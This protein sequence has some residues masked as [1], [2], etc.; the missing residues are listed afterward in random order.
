MADALDLAISGVNTPRT[1]FAPL[2]QI[3]DS[4]WSGLKQG[5]EQEKQ[6]A[7]K[8]I[9]PDDPDYYKKIT[10]TLFKYGDVPGAVPVAGLDIQDKSLAQVKRSNDLIQYGPQ[11]APQ[12]QQQAPNGGLPASPQQQLPAPPQNPAVSRPQ[13]DQA[14]NTVRTIFMAANRSGDPDDPIIENLA[15]RA[16]AHPD[17]PLPPQVA[18]RLAQVMSARAA[19]TPEQSAM[20][21]QQAGAGPQGAPQAPAP[22]QSQPQMAPQGTPVNPGAPQGAPQLGAVTDPSL[23][24]LVPAWALKAGMS[25]GDFQRFLR[26]QVAAMPKNPA[27]ASFVESMT[28]QADEIGTA[29]QKASEPTQ[30]QKLIQSNRQTINGVPETDSQTRSR[31]A[32]EIKIS[33]AVGTEQGK[34]IGDTIA[35]GRPAQS[36]IRSLQ[37]MR[38]ALDKGEGNFTTGPLADIVLKSKQ[39]IASAFNIPLEGVPE[40]EVASKIGFALASSATREISVRPAMFEFKQALAA[41][42]GL[43]LSPTGS[44]FMI[45]VMAQSARDNIELAKLAQ[46]RSNWGNWQDVVDNYYKAHPLKSPFDPSR[47]LNEADLQKLQSDPQANPQRTGAREQAAPVAITTK[48]ERDKL[49]PGTTYILG[50]KT[51]RT[52]ARTP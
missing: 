33:E 8:S 51:W 5:Q 37:V 24:G 10:Q 46:N 49:A 9:S 18:Q 38:A 7:L 31:M 25:A 42:P 4:Y 16:G 30:E 12:P 41:N 15:K 35:A 48:E 32:Q 43:L 47:S 3:P 29:L 11:G 26:N 27:T 19:L 45:S 21:T 44:R 17:Q 14:P 28:K 13:A 40:A 1:D 23:G 52:P 20:A 2:A 36:Q 6:K 34:V 50:G 39:A 22:V